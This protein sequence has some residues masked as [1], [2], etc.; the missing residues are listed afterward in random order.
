MRVQEEIDKAIDIFCQEERTEQ[1]EAILD[2]LENKLDDDE[3]EQKYFDEN[4]P[5]VEQSALSARQFLEEE[6]EFEEIG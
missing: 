6:I 2:V 3:I 5:W 4:D 1:V